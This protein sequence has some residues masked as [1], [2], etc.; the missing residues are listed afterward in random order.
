[1]TTTPVEVTKMSWMA[2]NE[3]LRRCTDESVLQHWLDV[4]LKSSHAARNTRCL[5]I[6]G[7]L[8]VVRRQRELKELRSKMKEAA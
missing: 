5:R 3:A 8:T 2:L 4:T 7:R 1:M 6:Y